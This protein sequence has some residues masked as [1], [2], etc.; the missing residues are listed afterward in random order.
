M[1]YPLPADLVIHNCIR[2]I[3]EANAFISQYYVSEIMHIKSILKT[4]IPVGIRTRIFCSWGGCNDR[5][6]TP[7]PKFFY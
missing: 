4:N 3:W 5:N 6:T 7:Q 2:S 1:I